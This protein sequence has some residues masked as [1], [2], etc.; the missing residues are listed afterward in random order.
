MHIN[1]HRISVSLGTLELRREG[2]ATHL[3][4]TEQGA[5]L[6]GYDN[7]KQRELGTVELFD[8]LATTLAD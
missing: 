5:F 6:D 8:K 4:Y 1:S 2:N 7:P 3:T